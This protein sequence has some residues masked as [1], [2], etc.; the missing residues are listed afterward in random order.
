MCC[1]EGH[2]KPG[3]SKRKETHIIINAVG[4]MAERLKTR[5][6]EQEKMV[7]LVCGPDAYR[8]LP[9]LLAI[10]DSKQTAGN[11]PP[12]SGVRKRIYCMHTSQPQYMQM[13]IV[14]LLGYYIFYIGTLLRLSNIYVEVL[15]IN[16]MLNI[17]KA[18]S[19]F[20][21]KT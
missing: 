4:C 15:G 7:D 14:R 1:F 16:V 10:T 8:D 13:H 3:H 21:T 17:V 19:H 12:S 6:L 11:F 5:I 20:S 2:G 9:R 18:K